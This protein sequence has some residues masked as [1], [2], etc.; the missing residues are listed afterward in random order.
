MVRIGVVDTTFA[1]VDMGGIAVE[2]LKSLDPNAV[3]Y[4]IT[5]PGVKNIPYAAAKLIKE[6]NCDG[7]LAT[8]WV[9]PALVDKISYLVM[10]IG[11][12]LLQIETMRPIIDVTVHEDEASEE[13]ELKMIA[14]DRTRK[15]AR[16]LIY[17]LRGDLSKW[18]GMGLRQGRPD[19]GPII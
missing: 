18:A 15:H 5:V 9:G 11:L 17:I 8:G 7:V 13:R 3:I 19:V 1:R 16:N 4:R 14:I 12:V 10:S 2:E 6:F